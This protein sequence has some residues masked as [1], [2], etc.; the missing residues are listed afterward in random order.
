MICLLCVLDISLQ[1]IQSYPYPVK[2]LQMNI[3]RAQSEPST[4]PEGSAD[5]EGF[6]HSIRPWS[7]PNAFT[8]GID[9]TGLH[10]AYMVLDP[11]FD[12]TRLMKHLHIPLS[13]ATA[14]KLDEHLQAL[15]KPA[16]NAVTELLGIRELLFMSLRKLN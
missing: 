14:H 3:R 16:R 2:E 7:N 6:R 10:G 11:T 8:E 13:V 15:L 12:L 5:G 4:D 1:F 9:G